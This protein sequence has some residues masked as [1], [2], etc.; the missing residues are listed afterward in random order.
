MS[1]GL[2]ESMVSLPDEFSK[3]KALPYSPGLTASLST[4]ASNDNGVAELQALLKQKSM[5]T[6]AGVNKLIRMKSNLEVVD[7][8]AEIFREG[9]E[10]QRSSHI[11]ETH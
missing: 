11:Q 4:D 7:E 8:E 9:E 2:T 5:S 3:A 1:E 10:S 6:A